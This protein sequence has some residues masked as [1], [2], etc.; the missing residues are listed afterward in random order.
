MM[1]AISCVRFIHIYK[2]AERVVVKEEMNEY[3]GRRCEIGYLVFASNLVLS[4]IRINGDSHCTVH[5]PLCYFM[6]R[7]A[8]F[9]YLKQNTVIMN[10]MSLG[11]HLL[12]PNT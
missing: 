2:T 3:S 12:F 5:I 8:Q 4:L 6:S 7:S 11:S 9:P 10:V 1:I